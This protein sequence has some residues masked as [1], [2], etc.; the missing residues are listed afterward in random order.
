MATFPWKYCAHSNPFRTKER[1][2]GTDRTQ[3][4]LADSR[5]TADLRDAPGRELN[6][7]GAGVTR[8]LP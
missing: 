4:A 7:E 5:A 1:I 8:D 3:D 6:H 2:S